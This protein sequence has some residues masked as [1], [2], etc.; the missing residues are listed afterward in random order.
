MSVMAACCCE[1]SPGCGEFT[2]GG[3]YV[4]GKL[5]FSFAEYGHTRTN[6]TTIRCN[7]NDPFPIRGV[8][9]LDVSFS[10][11]ISVT[12]DF[13]AEVDTTDPIGQFELDQFQ[14]GSNQDPVET[15]W[16][17]NVSI[18]VDGR[19]EGEF[20]NRSAVNPN[21]SGCDDWYYSDLFKESNG[22][23]YLSPNSTAARPLVFSSGWY[24]R[25]TERLTGGSCLDK[26][27]FL[28][29]EVSGIGVPIAYTGEYSSGDTREGTCGA[30][31]DTEYEN[32]NVNTQ[33]FFG[34]RTLSYVSANPDDAIADCD[35]VPGTT[36]AGQISPIPGWPN[37]FSLNAF[38]DDFIDPY[39][40]AP[41]CEELW[42][43]NLAPNQVVRRIWTEQDEFDTSNQCGG[44][45]IDYDQGFVDKRL[46][47]GYYG[48]IHSIVPTNVR[49]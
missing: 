15:G 9:T 6:T 5:T 26:A 44:P 39:V 14:P 48:T 43:R 2:C 49:P 37:K 29:I 10:K 21:S 12:F 33:Q 32:Q 24:I 35:E 23:I 25:A 18:T 36:Y 28:D 8:D 45:I 27:C 22:E 7:P 17:R 38:Q 42:S 19:W 20:L 13:T 47:H 34:F 4:N 40:G 41:E 1:P 11:Y 31:I 16:I 46:A 3:P 30:I